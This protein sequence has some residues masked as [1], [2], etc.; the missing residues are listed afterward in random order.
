MHSHKSG[1]LS[2]AFSEK[3]LRLGYFSQTNKINCTNR[4]KATTSR[5]RLPKSMA[6]A[7]VPDVDACTWRCKASSWPCR[8][9]SRCM[10]SCCN[11]KTGSS[12]FWR[13]LSGSLTPHKDFM[14]LP[15]SAMVST[16]KN[17]TSVIYLYSITGVCRYV[18]MYVWMYFYP[19]DFY[20][21]IILMHQHQSMVASSET[22]EVMIH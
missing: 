6:P 3:S 20:N 5:S 17:N 16:I 18:F 8:L 7:L 2:A 12:A 11:L 19:N 14:L 21:T 10:F 22:V 1:M 13:E 9:V 15:P 4:A